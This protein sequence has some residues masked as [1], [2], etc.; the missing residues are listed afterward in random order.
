MSTRLAFSTDPLDSFLTE[1]NCPFCLARP[2]HPLV[3][4]FD[5]IWYPIRFGGTI[6]VETSAFKL[7]MKCKD[8]RYEYARITKPTSLYTVFS[9]SSNFPQ[10][11]QK[12]LVSFMS[13]PIRL[14]SILT[15]YDP[16]FDFIDRSEAQKSK[17]ATLVMNAVQVSLFLKEPSS[18]Y[19]SQIHENGLPFPSLVLSMSS[20][21]D[22][23]S[24]GQNNASYKTNTSSLLLQR[25]F[26][27]DAAQPS[28][29]EGF[30]SSSLTACDCSPGEYAGYGY[31]YGYGYN[32]VIKCTDES[33]KGLS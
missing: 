23:H 32:S 6:D 13:L 26:E 24:K 29:E 11:Q 19:S 1:S 8:M 2:K 18:R 33:N 3:T 20:P 22:K 7:K 12:A 25:T 15:A 9:L 27:E 10:T 31:G 5:R 30:C 21:V 14:Y 17:I 16:S 4:S 28:D